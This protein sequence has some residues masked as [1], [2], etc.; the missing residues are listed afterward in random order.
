MR[1]TTIT[2]Q[3]AQENPNAPRPEIF[4]ENIQE[5]IQENI[6]EGA[7][8]TNREA[9]Q[10]KVQE[11]G[12]V[13]E[14]DNT[15]FPA[16]EDPGV[17][18]P[19]KPIYRS[20]LRPVPVSSRPRIAH[21]GG[22]FLIVGLIV[23]IGLGAFFTRRHYKAAEVVASING[24]VIQQ[25]EFYIELE[26]SVGPKVMQHMVEDALQLQFAEK[27]GAAPTDAELEVRYAADMKK[28]DAERYMQSSGITTDMYKH[29]LRLNMA[30]IKLVT[31][32]VTVTDIEVQQE[33]QA[34]S[35]AKN[36][37]ARYY[38]PPI[39][40][41]AVIITQTESNCVKALQDLHAGLPF[42]TVAETYSIDASKLRGG[43]LE[44]LPR[45]RKV[46]ASIPG[47]EET[48]FHMKIGKQ[49]GPLQFAK[50][51]WIIRCLNRT[52]AKT[53]TFTQVASDCREVALFAK[54]LPLNSK[55]IEQEY[56]AFRKTAKIQ[57]FWDQYKEVVKAR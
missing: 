39:A 30:K 28:P 53:Q 6:H 1:T 23:G 54:G 3:Q 42:A 35:D 48:I 2:M 57:A 22:A 4:H 34:N 47:F 55:K 15:P 31:Q 9:T 40:D 21:I 8:E 50:K 46:S 14:P 18:K 11:R 32:G 7:R 10:D 37:A 20:A 45:G 25:R 19:D 13:S 44:P 24:A 29:Q 12:E 16:Q 17:S 52:E 49:V 43:L 56:N 33:Y 38:T 27:M 26:R 51:W 41:L 36:S 5:D